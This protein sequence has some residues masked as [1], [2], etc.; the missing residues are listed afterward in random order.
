M[1][2]LD[3]WR[4]QRE[5]RL[6]VVRERQQEVRSRI[7][8]LQM[9][10]LTQ[11][12]QERSLRQQ[13]YFNLQRQIQEFLTETNSNRRIQAELLSKELDDFVRSLSSQISLFLTVTAKDREKMAV[14]T[15]KE[16]RDFCE[17]LSLSLADLREQRQARIRLLKTQTQDFLTTSYLQR[18]QVQAQLNRQLTAW[19]EALRSDIQGYLQELELLRE[20]RRRRLHQSF[21]ESRL[22]RLTDVR[23]M[24]DRHARFQA[25]LQEY[26]KNLQFEVWGSQ[27]QVVSQMKQV[28]TSIKSAVSSLPKRVEVEVKAEVV[29][30]VAP[31]MKALQERSVYNYL[32]KGKG[33]RLTE[34]EAAT[35]LNRVQTV[36]ALRSLLKQGLIVQRDRLYSTLETVK[37][38]VTMP[39]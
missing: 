27:N 25:K 29:E 1:V 12:G 35:G 11:G 15:S 34:I 38:S 33:V 22:Q 2:L 30:V 17:N 13:S 23:E 21:Q 31:N 32:R 19:L 20:G 36:D 4:S 10:R 37:T 28:E 24:R 3:E 14:E 16:L 6:D 18:I 26:R 9:S 39:S 5:E 8:Q 7:A